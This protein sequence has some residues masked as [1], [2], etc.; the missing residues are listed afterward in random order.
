MIAMIAQKYQD[1]LAKVKPYIFTYKKNLQYF[2][3][4]PL[5]FEIE[6]QY[7]FDCTHRDSE[8]FFNLIAK[9]DELAFGDQGMGMDRWVLYD[10]SA[11]PGAIFGFGV[12]ALELSKEM[13]IKMDIAV[14]YEGLVPI[15]MFIA[16]PTIEPEHWFGHNLSSLNKQLDGHYPGLGLITKAFGLLSMKITKQYGATQ[17]NNTAIYIHSRLADLK[18]VTAYTPI[19]SRKMTLT[20]LAKYTEE[21]IACAMSGSRE[22]NL[23]I[24]SKLNGS[25]Q[26]QIIDIQGHIEEGENLYITGVEKSGKDAVIYSINNE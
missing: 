14:D 21:S 16:I 7:Q 5:G 11:M 4:K 2:D 15:S 23:V 8:I 9:M 3:L 17:W 19:H 22:S 26:K 18:L 20:Y 6:T 25:D 10:C 13:R 1:T 12:E 24:S